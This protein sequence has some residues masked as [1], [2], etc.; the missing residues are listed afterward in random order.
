MRIVRV[1]GC[2]AMG[3]LA[4]T[5]SAG[6][7]AAVQLTFDLDDGQIFVNP[8]P[9]Y[10]SNDISL[11]SPMTVNPGES[12]EIW[13][14]F[15][16]AQT[17]LK[18]HLEIADDGNDPLPENFGV[19]VNGSGIPDGTGAE[20]EVELSGVSGSLIGGP[21]FTK[22]DG[23]CFNNSCNS[24]VFDVDLTDD[25]FFFHDIHITFTPTGLTGPISI[26]NVQFGFAVNTVNEADIIGV[27]PMPEPG[28]LALFG[29]GLL[30]LAAMS[31][32]NRERGPVRSK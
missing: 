10:S 13:I 21:T 26:S 16:D 22:D 30:G 2:L 28:A 9:N 23:G 11:G 25:S 8:D 29:F 24:F 15:F 4:A 7:A 19:S 5:L 31:W 14:D 12:L 17:G 20:F 32:R 3:L 18:Q 27:W 1:G 6:S